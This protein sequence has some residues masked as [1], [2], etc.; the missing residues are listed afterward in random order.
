MSGGSKTQTTTTNQT[1][2]PYAPTIPALGNIVAGATSAYNSGVGSQ[3]YQGDRVAGIGDTTQSGLDYL[4]NNA[5][6]G[7]AAAQ[8]GNNLL[9]QLLGN[10]G[11]TSGI[12][13]ALQGL[14]G[15][16]TADT[17]GVASAASRMADPNSAA[18]TVGRNLV[19][20]QFNLDGSGY[21]SLADQLGTGTQTQRSLQDVAN[22]RFLDESNP[23]TSAMI[24]QG[25]G[26]A[27]SAV[28]QKFAASGRYGSGRFA[29]AV[30]DATDRVGTQ[31][32]YQDYSTE[33]DRQAQAA[34]AIDSA[35][36]ARTGVQSS[37]LDQ[38]NGVRT[39]N[40]GQ[41]VT[42][43]NLSS[44][45]DAA[46]LTGANALANLVGANNA[47]QIGQ[48]SAA[49][50]SGQSDRAAGLA[51]LGAVAT[52]NA[53]LLAPGQ[54][55]AGVG[56]VQDQA[57]QDQLDASKAVFDEGQQAPWKQLG[58]YSSLID[59]IAGLGGT[60][61]GTET[62]TIPQPSAL[63]QILGTAATG[64]G[65]LGQ[66]G[67]FPTAAKAAGS[68][69]WLSALPGFLG[70]SDE[71]AK[72]D[73]REV[74]RLHDGQAV[75]AYRYKGDPAPQIGLLAQEVAERYPHAVGEMPGGGGL[76]GV[77]Y[78]AATAPSARIAASRGARV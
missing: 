24:S 42:G 46:A 36:N 52:N 25:A 22:G 54:T 59:P 32:R 11:T 41:A 31:L 12:Q 63:Q 38:I 4:K 37:L 73:I 39:A 28:A 13:S 17:S 1:K 19:G 61:T 71:R 74:G 16:G 77:D 44:G 30:A 18:A 8:G 78:A 6:A 51:G 5:T 58:L 34:G 21:Q 76:L 49:L 60:S 55:L 47:Q 70:L 50:S 35:A 20:G 14:L 48:Q 56:A 29:G 43:A 3:V 33:R 23:Y 40:A 72:E 45:A 65:L 2:D 66:T 53:N 7:S 64:V 57:R 62:K 75:Y 69:G 26:D 15:V 67:A 68:A 9:T 27:A 10:G